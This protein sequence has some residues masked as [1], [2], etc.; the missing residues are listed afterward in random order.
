[1][2]PRPA[3]PL[4]KVALALVGAL[5]TA[6]TVR[7]ERLATARIAGETLELTTDACAAAR[8]DTVMKR[9]HKASEGLVVDG[10]W[11]VDRRGDP[12]VRWHDGEVQNLR[13]EQLELAP[14]FQA[15]LRRIDAME[16]AAR[17][18]GAGTAAAPPGFA[19]PAWCAQ[20][21]QP[22]ERLIC[23]EPAL[24]QADLA[25]APLWRQFKTRMRLDEAQLRHYKSSFYRRLKAC[26]EDAACIA[27]EQA[28]RTRLYRV[29]LG[30]D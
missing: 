4:L 15:A 21:R 10:C 19:R 26:G 2:K 29:A 27:N 23:R 13:A 6:A 17:T 14:K 5:G 25:L 24:A 28:V 12:V 1:M 9:A 16:A 30:L 11:W 22:H 7:A 20:A 3:R 18:P 8:R